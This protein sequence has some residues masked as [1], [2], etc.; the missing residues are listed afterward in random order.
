MIVGY[1][2]D[3]L[4]WFKLAHEQK[5]NARYGFVDIYLTPIF[6]QTGGALL[7]R[8]VV[9]GYQPLSSD[10]VDRLN[11]SFPR[12]ER[13]NLQ[14]AALA[15]N[16]VYALSSA[17]VCCPIDEAECVVEFLKKEPPPQTLLGFQGFGKEPAYPV[18]LSIFKGQQL[19][20]I[21]SK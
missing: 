16:A 5:L 17:L 8:A 15:Y 1:E 18:Q 11:E 2:N 3:H 4:G 9:F 14:G 6:L 21:A 13:A 12:P 7:D 19:S 10:F 20:A